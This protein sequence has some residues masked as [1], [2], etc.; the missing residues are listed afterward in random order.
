MANLKSTILTALALTLPYAASAKDL[1]TEITVDRTVVPVEKEAFRLGS[2][3]PQLMSSQ[4]KQR[5]LTLADYTTPATLTRTL[6]TLDPAAYADTFALSPYK[7]Y[8]AIGYFPVFNL[9]AS[10][11]YRFIDTSRTKLG[12]W[13]QYDGYSYKESGANASKGTFNNNTVTIGARFD[14]RVG[15][16][17][18]LGVGLSYTHAALGMPDDFYNNSQ[19]AN[20]FDADLSWWSRTGLI[21]YHAKLA[22]SYFGYGKDVLLSGPDVLPD[23]DS[24]GAGENRIT[25]NAGIG[26]FGSSAAPRGGIEI[27]ADF[28]GRNN[29]YEQIGVQ[30]APDRYEPRIAPIDAK[31]LGVISLTPYYAFNSGSIH[32]RIGAKIE[33]SSGG[34]GK[35]IHI[36]PAVMLDWNVASQFAI[37]AQVDGGE[38]LNSL[39]SLF[40]YCPY[41]NA[42]WQYQRS[43]VPVTFDLGMNIGPFAGFSAR[44]FGGYA[45]AND[46]LMPQL[47]YF[48]TKMGEQAVAMSS[49]GKYDMKGWHAGVGLSYDWRSVVKADVSAEAAPQK[50]DRGYYL[51]RDRAKYVIKAGIEVRPISQLKIGV[52]YELRDKR[53]NY[54]YNGEEYLAINLKSV[55]NLSLNASYAL[56]DAF[57]IFARGENLLNHRYNLVTDIEAQGIKGLVG[58]T[59][60]F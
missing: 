25:F 33:L 36:A 30:T 9:G 6:S 17:S 16:K 20:I 34:E 55:S 58:V 49:F 57:T 47:T 3:N 60:K 54:L 24:K 51:W 31:T 12:A 50:T 4:V 15:E 7:G 27:S 14:Q 2:L 53:C 22:Y 19:N 18:R 21:G 35:K 26:Y 8:A 38:R 40:D 29:G 32:G 59:Y 44:I 39:R 13:L 28:I 43:H 10:A 11:G 52:G 45:V 23:I 41:M 46:W 37:Y 42:A 1:K 56:N 48:Q 5:R